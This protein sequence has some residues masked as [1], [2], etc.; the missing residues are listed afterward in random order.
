MHEFLTN[1]E[2]VIDLGVY[3]F[4]VQILLNLYNLFNIYLCCIE[5][6]TK[7]EESEQLTTMPKYLSKNVLHLV[8]K[9]FVIEIIW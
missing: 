4:F 2:S 7:K 1:I 8:K 3:E 5:L 9:C 6:E